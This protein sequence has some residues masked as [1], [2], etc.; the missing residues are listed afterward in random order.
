MKTY[1]KA[2]FT[3]APP[4]RVWNVWSDPNNWTRWNTGIK[5]FQ[6]NGPLVSGAVGKMQT[7]Q[8]TTHDVT[9]E[10]VEPLK[11]FRLSTGGPPLTRFTFI[12][13]VQPQGT[14]STISQSVAFSG[15]L[16]FLFGP[17]FGPQMATHF[18]PVL[19]DLAAAAEATSG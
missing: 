3:T 5:N 4:E 16:A 19:E 11:G 13:E 14:G 18:V 6:M 15:P 9:F 7:S 8:G 2:R 17:L 12:C 10:R 1:G